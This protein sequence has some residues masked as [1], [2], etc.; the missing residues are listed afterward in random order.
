MAAFAVVTT[1]S[2]SGEDNDRESARKKSS[3]KQNSH[4]HEHPFWKEFIT[5]G[6]SVSI[7]NVATLPIDVLKV[8]LQL[9]NAT[10]THSQ[11]TMKAGLLRTAI[12]IAKKEGI[13]AFYLGLTPALARGLF[14]GGVRLGAYGPIKN[15]LKRVA[16]DDR[17]PSIKF[18]RN[19]TAGCLSGSI[20]AITSNPID[21]CKTKLQAKHSPYTSSIH[22]IKDV[23]RD[24]GVR[25][26]WVGTVPAVIR[27]AVLTAAQCVTYDHAK[28]FVSRTTGLSEGVT[29][30]LGASLITGLVTT[31]VTAPLDMIKTNMYATGDYG[32]MEL[33]HKIVDNE[34]FRGLLRG[35]SAQYVRLG[36]QTVVIFLAMEKLRQ[37]SGLSAL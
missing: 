12:N 36:P 21:L 15:I 18:L 28:R 13:H 26:L 4:I 2:F 17:R 25:G 3:D 20:A 5:S 22:V 14:Y 33:I 9:A 6:V 23:I 34:G 10:I 11:S 1:Q 30:H 31:T 8:R 27:T 7:A 35:W 37:F 32:A 16:T 24:H 29:L 19:V